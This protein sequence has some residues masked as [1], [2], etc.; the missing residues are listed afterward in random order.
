[1]RRSGISATRVKDT[2]L[3]STVRFHG[4]LPDSADAEDH[5]HLRSGPST[6]GELEEA[7]KYISGWVVRGLPRA[8]GQ[9]CVE[10]HGCVHN[11]EL[12]MRAPECRVS[13]QHTHTMN[14]TGI[15]SPYILMRNSVPGVKLDRLLLDVVLAMQGD[16]L[17]SPDNPYLPECLRNMNALHTAKPV[18]QTF[19]RSVLAEIEAL[20]TAEFIMCNHR[21]AYNRWIQ[22]LRNS[23]DLWEKWLEMLRG[24]GAVDM[25]A[26]M[27]N[28]ELKASMR[29]LQGVFVEKFMHAYQ[30]AMLRKLHLLASATAQS[31]REG[32]K[33]YSQTPTSRQTEK[34][35][36][37][38]PAAPPAAS[39]PPRQTGPTAA[40]PPP[41]QASPAAAPPPAPQQHSGAP[42]EVDG[43]APQQP[44]TWVPVVCGKDD[45]VTKQLHVKARGWLN[46]DLYFTQLTA[47]RC[48][49]AKGNNGQPSTRTPQAGA[50]IRT[51]D[52]AELIKPQV[53]EARGGKGNQSRWKTSLLVEVD[54]Q[55]RVPLGRWLES[56]ARDRQISIE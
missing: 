28:S 21:R 50:C 41:G 53:L 11:T 44:G 56:A 6:E 37:S 51:A 9:Y 43:P 40:P 17:P 12:V 3:P 20:S 45:P 42:M 15:A 34:A 46:V 1:M 4:T 19:L 14:R 24:L 26:L 48:K 10:G 31:L 47:A 54:A 8:P 36:N 16:R 30:K 7:V 38:R 49:R 33:G 52:D 35:S 27:T 25:Q 13:A 2:L 32:L 39:N 22:H 23:Q 18:V 5:P 29:K 55:Q